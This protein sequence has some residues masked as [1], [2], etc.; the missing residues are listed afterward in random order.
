HADPHEFRITPTQD[1]ALIIG[2]RHRD[3][4]LSIVGGGPKD[5]VYD[6]FVQEVDIETGDLLWEWDATDFLDLR[7]TYH[8][9]DDHHSWEFAHTN[10]VVKDEDGNYIIS[11]R[12]Y[13]SIF[14]ID[15]RTK[16]IIWTLGG[17]GSDFTFGNGSDFV[18]QHDPQWV[19]VF[20]HSQ[21]TIFDNDYDFV[22]YKGPYGTA[23]GIWIRLDYSA[24]HVT[25]VREYIPRVRKRTGIEGG[26]QLLPNGNVLVSY[27]SS[28]SVIEYCHT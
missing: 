16:D 19:P 15:G 8:R 13:H 2:G 24:M 11:Y 3:Y 14:K 12:F 22:G 25:L 4:D 7:N 1:S 23:R 27:G 18:G 17:K 10:A 26:I 9:L 5:G 20:S 21:M 28:G 6:P